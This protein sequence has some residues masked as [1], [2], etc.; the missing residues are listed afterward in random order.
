MK[1]K[2]KFNFATLVT[3][4]SLGVG[5]LISGCGDSGSTTPNPLNG[6][7]T[8]A[9]PTPEPPI[10]DTYKV[11]FQYNSLAKNLGRIDVASDIVNVKYAFYGRTENKEFVTAP[12]K[13]HE[14]KHET[15]AQEQ[16]IAVDATEVEELNAGIYA[17][18][19]A[20]YDESDNLVAVGYDTIDWQD[21]KTATI[22]EPN[23]YSLTDNDALSLTADKYVVKPSE[24]VTLSLKLTP[25]SSATK[26]Y[27]LTPFATFGQLNDIDNPST[28]SLAADEN[29]TN[30]QFKAVAYGKVK[31]VASLGTQISQPI[32]ELIYVTDQTPNSLELRPANSQISFGSDTKTDV[33]K[34]F[35]LT[36]IPEPRDLGE[37]ETVTVQCSDWKTGNTPLGEVTFALGEVP[38]QAIATYTKE[39]DKGPQPPL[40][41]IIKDVEL[42]TAFSGEGVATYYGL[43]SNNG[44]LV[45]SVL[46]N[47]YSEWETYTVTAKYGQL[48][49]TNTVFVGGFLG[50]DFNFCKKDDNGNLVAFKQPAQMLHAP[51]EHKLYL[52]GTMKFENLTVGSKI[53][54]FAKEPFFLREDFVG[55]YDYPECY[56]INSTSSECTGEGESFRRAADGSNEYIVTLIDLGGKHATHTLYTEEF[57]NPG[58]YVTGLN[59]TT[60][61]DQLDLLSIETKL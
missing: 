4:V 35:F 53:L 44:T 5:L 31:P 61:I 33:D 37:K 1:Y 41:D 60:S 25:S 9:P 6:G 42:T 19:A 13:A 20:Y 59:I 29:A 39:P 21:G 58:V 38:M 43:D 8:P 30:G 47:C 14:F 46:G 36:Y 48:K 32:D 27:D 34:S 54:S 50:S 2:N 51:G 55:K 26:T 10:S 23:L 3:T 22:A 16:D 49:D 18:T 45:A 7:D 15:S 12:T 40:S 24:D 17:V 56:I 52:A 57:A 11:T 28:V